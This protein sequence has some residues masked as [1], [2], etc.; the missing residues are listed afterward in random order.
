M[1]EMENRFFLFPL[2]F[3]SSLYIFEVIKL[4]AKRTEL[5]GNYG[6]NYLTLK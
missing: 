1:R 3:F 5:G 4:E 6:E 2:P